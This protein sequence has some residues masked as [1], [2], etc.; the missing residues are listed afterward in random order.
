MMNRYIIPVF[1][2][3]LS[4]GVYILYGDPIYASIAA[5]NVKIAE[6]DKLLADAKDATQKI[7]KLRATQEQFP[8]GYDT[9][10]ATILPNSVDPLRLV[11]DVN[12]IAALR[13]LY[14]KSP[15]VT[16]APDANKD[17]GTVQKNM[18][19]FTISAPYSVFRDFLRDLESSLSLQDLSQ[20]TFT[21]TSLT[22]DTATEN[23]YL[24]HPDLRPYEYLVSAIT[25][26]LPK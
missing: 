10:L 26:S 18:L 6:D 20:L 3:L 14:I 24:A 7:D 12:G 2:V 8:S 9:S 25:Y 16:V 23:Y 11:I 4:A 5:G 22:T 15:Q 21:S 17:T 1:L 19:T 13:G